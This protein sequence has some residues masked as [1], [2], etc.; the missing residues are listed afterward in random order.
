MNVLQ[1][2]GSQVFLSCLATIIQFIVKQLG[3][4]WDD[5]GVAKGAA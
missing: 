1:K 2:H 3:L 5:G 4:N